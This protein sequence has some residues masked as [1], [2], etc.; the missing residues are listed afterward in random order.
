[1]KSGIRRP[2]LTLLGAA[3][4]ALGYAGWSRSH[5]VQT[6]ATP[7]AS[8]VG[9]LAPAPAAASQP[10]A[11]RIARLTVCDSADCLANLSAA[12]DCAA[13]LG[14]AEGRLFGLEP[15]S[16]DEPWTT[17]VDGGFAA[18]A[19]GERRAERYGVAGARNLDGRDG[20][21]WRR[22]AHRATG[23]PEPLGVLEGALEDPDPPGV[24]LKPSCRTTGWLL[25]NLAQ[26]RLRVAFWV[27]S[28]SAPPRFAILHR[29]IGRIGQDCPQLPFLHCNSSNVE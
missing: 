19:P 20:R 25:L 15:A 26:S 17:I 18:A 11:L 3:V 9:A 29:N 22:P 8:L 7:P 2:A 10:P 6:A 4:I 14:G 1:M 21:F 28:R 24:R 23:R 13:C 27:L 12:D 5:G 16:A